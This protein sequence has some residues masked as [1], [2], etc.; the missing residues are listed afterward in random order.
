[1]AIRSR[2]TRKIVGRGATVLLTLVGVATL[3][4]CAPTVP[5]QGAPTASLVVP[6]VGSKWVVAQRDSGSYGSS[7]KQITYARLED[8]VWQG[9]KARAYSDG[10]T[11]RLVDIDRGMTIAVVKGAELLESFE[12][13]VGWQWPLWTGKSWLGTFRYTDHSRGRT[14]NSIQAWYKVAAYEDV[15]VPAGKFRTLRVDSD[16]DRGALVSSSWWNPETG[17][18]VKSRTERSARYYLGPGVRET[19]LT[20]YEIKR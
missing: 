7:S 1:M 9:R 4:A 13:G 17:L 18:T 5:P 2:R 11:T 15:T 14:F 8:Q 6:P 20:S 10:S 19:E 3:A 16:G 12:P